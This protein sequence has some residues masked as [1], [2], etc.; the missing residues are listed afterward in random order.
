MVASPASE[1]LDRKVDCDEAPRVIDKAEHFE[2]APVGD[3]PRAGFRGWPRSLAPGLGWSASVA[4]VAW[5]LAHVIPVLGPPVLAILIGIGLGTARRPPAT[6]TA[7]IAFA[8]TRLLQV[9][10]VLLGTS[11]GLGEIVRVGGRSLPVML[12][13]LAVALVGAFALGRLLDVGPRLR[14]LIGVGT[15]ICGASAIAAVS[16]IVRASETEIAYAISTIF[17]F[18][19]VAVVLFPPLGHLLDLSQHGFGLWAG[20][21]VNDTSSVVATAYAY[22]HVAGVQAVVV[23]LTRTTLLVPI[24]L[25]L[26]ALRARAVQSD[27]GP[28]VRITQLVPGFLVLFVVAA[29]LDTAGLIPTA[30]HGPLSDAALALITVALA[31]V[32]LSSDL[33]RMRRVGFRPLLLGALLWVS[34]ASASLLL[35]ALTDQL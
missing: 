8:A 24:A 28:R 10:I 31:G 2:D 32:G 25:G 30:L 14:A 13:T 18:N 33:V 7:G 23:K 27:S 15:G 29:A 5:L 11:L 17:V 26:S 21:A 4:F 1:A 20:T 12:G 6:A 3:A 22:G 34:V 9:A 35:Q 19:I 16:G